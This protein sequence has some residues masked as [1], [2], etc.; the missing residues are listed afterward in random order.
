MECKAKKVF[1]GQSQMFNIASLLFI[2]T[3]FGIAFLGGELALAKN[4]YG[5]HLCGYS[6]FTCSQ[7]RRG[8]TW[9]K[10]FPNRRDREIV[11][12][13]NRTNIPLR[14]RS[15]IVIPNDL[16]Y[17][18]YMDISPFPDQIDPPGKRLLYVKLSLQAFGAYD[19]NGNLMHWGPVSGG[20]NWCNDIGRPCRTATGIFRIIRKQG[21]ECESTRFPIETNGGAPMPYCMHYFRG[22]ALHGSTLPGYHASHGCIRLFHDDAKWLNKHFTRIGT[23]VIV[24]K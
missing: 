11:K 13:L 10:R 3:I 5:S 6:D 22:F 23:K 4:Y 19:E 21:P 9:A 7:V 15:W 17:I 1:F 2:F 8:D 12:R 24:T 20:R 14:Y 16:N 18:D